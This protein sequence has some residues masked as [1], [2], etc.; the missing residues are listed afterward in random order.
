MV[1]LRSDKRLRTISGRFWAARCGHR[2]VAVGFF[3]LRQRAGR[4]RMYISFPGPRGAGRGTDAEDN[5]DQRCQVHGATMPPASMVDVVE[6][7]SEAGAGTDAEDNIVQRH[8]VHVKRM[9]LHD[10]VFCIP[11]GATARTTRNGCLCATLMPTHQ[12]RVGIRAGAG[13]PHGATQKRQEIEDNLLSLLGCD[14]RR[15]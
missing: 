10:V 6:Q 7:D 5:I 11:H 14:S 4:P 2:T 9:S 1:Q 3:F 15:L 13:I 8:S 12:R